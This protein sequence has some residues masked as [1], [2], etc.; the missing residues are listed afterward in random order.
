VTAVLDPPMPV[1]PVNPL[2]TPIT[3]RRS[4]VPVGRAGQPAAGPY[5]YSVSMSQPGVS[6]NLWNIPSTQLSAPYGTV[7][8]GEPPATPAALPAGPYRWNVSVQDA[9]RNNASREADF[10]VT[11]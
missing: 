8:P 4:G 11:F 6:W 2:A 10:A 9:Q 3:A 1:F 7:N 5:T